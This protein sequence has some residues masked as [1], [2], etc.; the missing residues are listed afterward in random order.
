[1]RE[2]AGPNALRLSLYFL[3]SPTS[4][5][6]LLVVPASNGPPSHPTS[7]SSAGEDSRSNLITGDHFSLAVAPRPL[8]LRQLVS[9]TEM[10]RTASGVSPPSRTTMRPAATGQSPRRCAFPDLRPFLATVPLRCLASWIARLAGKGESI[11]PRLGPSETWLALT[12]HGLHEMS[13]PLL[14]VNPAAVMRSGKN[15]RTR[16]SPPV[17]AG[18]LEGPLSGLCGRA[19]S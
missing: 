2:W 1:M 7:G 16:P 8:P 6:T 14:R 17:A 13:S 3:L 15:R 18:P 19:S 4:S 12:S 11:G 5:L 10:W 9:R